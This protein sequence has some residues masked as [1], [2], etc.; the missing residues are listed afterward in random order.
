MSLS[1]EG[2][3][4]RKKTGREGQQG[5]GGLP[6]EAGS[7]VEQVCW[8]GLGQAEPWVQE[9]GGCPWLTTKAASKGRGSL[10][11]SLEKGHTDTPH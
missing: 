11:K 6:H 3:A 10:H 4:G 5:L 8:V 1:L 2:R 9:G 7:R